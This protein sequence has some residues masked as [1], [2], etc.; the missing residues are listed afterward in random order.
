MI[1]KKSPATS[2]SL[3]SPH[4]PAPR[5]QAVSCFPD[6]ERGLLLGGLPPRVNPSLG[7]AIPVYRAQGYTVMSIIFLALK[8]NDCDFTP[9]TFTSTQ[10]VSLERQ[11]V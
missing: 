9:I 5:H 11:Y 3:L 7:M 8:L 6:T 10:Y 1:E 4:L 2:W